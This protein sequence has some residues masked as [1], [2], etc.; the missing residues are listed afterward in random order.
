MEPPTMRA[1][2]RDVAATGIRKVLQL[3][4]AVRP[5]R[6]TASL[7]GSGLLVVN[8]PFRFDTEAQPILDWLWRALSPAGEGGRRVRWLAPE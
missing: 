5:E 4:L 6:W 1:F 2:E 3:E 8:P 7:R